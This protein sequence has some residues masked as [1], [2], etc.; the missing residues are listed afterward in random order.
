M[1]AKLK[2]RP[3]VASRV[4]A[5]RR[6]ERGPGLAFPFRLL[7]G[8]AVIA[9]GVGV[10]VLANGGLGRIASAVGSTVDGLVADLTSTPV[11]SAPDPVAANAP[12]LEAPEEPYTNDKSIDL[13]GTIPADIV[14][15]VDWRIR[16]YVAIGKGEPGILIEIPVGSSQHFLVP[17]L[18]LSPGQNTFTASIVGPTDLESDFSAAVTYVLDTSKPRIIISSPKKN[19]TVNGKTVQVVGKTQARSQLSIRNVT[20]SATVTGAADANGSFK[21]AIPIGTGSNKIQVTSTDPAGNV[22]TATVTVRRGTGKLTAALTASF[23]QVKKSHLPEQVRLNVVVTD[24]DGRALAGAHVVF[25]LAVPGIP[26]ITSSTLATSS[27]GRASFTTTIPR[28][29]SAGQTSV[30]V[31]VETDDFGDTTDRTVIT[32]QS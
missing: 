28:G 17:G 24:P 9:L 32:I 20:T 11:P 21:I 7:L 6:V 29:A 14:N 19:A 3:T 12:N 13:V 15:Q 22:N 30:T 1:P 31:I 25:T 8:V 2:P 5:H 26:A 16:I 27:T 18:A 23:Y 10:L 4:A